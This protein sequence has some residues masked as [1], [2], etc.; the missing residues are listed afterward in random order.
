MKNHD[1]EKLMLSYESG[2]RHPE[3]SGMEH[4]NLFQVR[5]RL[6]RIKGELTDS[7]RARLERA[8]TE[9]LRRASEFLN[10]I[11]QIADLESWRRR[12]RVPPSQWWWYLDVVVNVPV[13]IVQPP[14]HGF[15]A[16]VAPA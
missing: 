2:V 14:I 12:D 7:Q 3:A 15:M 6:A 5:S 4:L 8:D 16:E 1:N 11:E 10:S 9:L 13:M